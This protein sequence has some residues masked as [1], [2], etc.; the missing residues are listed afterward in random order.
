MDAH[1]SEIIFWDKHLDLYHNP[2]GNYFK[3]G[4]NP[5]GGYIAD[6]TIIKKDERYHLFHIERKHGGNCAWPGH[7]IYFGHSST[8]D[9]VTWE[10]HM[11]VLFIQPGTWEGSHVFAPY[12]MQYGKMYVMFYTGLNEDHSQSIGMAFSKDL[13]YWERYYGNPIFQLANCEWACWAR[14]VVSSCRDPHVFTENG[15][16]HLYYTAVKKTGETCIALATSEDLYN[17]KDEGA[18]F[19]LKL[20]YGMK[21]VPGPRHIESSCVHR[22]G[23]QYY[24]FYGHNAGVRYNRSNDQ[25]CFGNAEGEM[26]WSGFTG[27]EVIERQDPVWLVSAF[28]MSEQKLF[29]GIIDWSD[30]KPVVSLPEDSSE[31]SRFLR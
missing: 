12:V 18:V 13:F 10:T 19:Y 23:E 31:I 8:S 14:N 27:F 2:K 6:F 11:P 21:V 16:M 22:M 17:W 4:F 25:K 26:I 30:S 9:F 24:L 15:K 20:D 3:E 5:R 29:V 1:E 28:E 7:E